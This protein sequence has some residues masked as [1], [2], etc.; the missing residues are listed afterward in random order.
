MA[1]MCENKH[2]DLAQG[3]SH[4]GALTTASGAG[5]EFSEFHPFS[6]AQA[7]AVSAQV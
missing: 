3:W 7:G 6:T 4:P 5:A 1:A 2:H